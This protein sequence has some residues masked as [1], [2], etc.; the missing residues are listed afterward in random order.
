MK[1]HIYECHLIVHIEVTSLEEDRAQLHL[2][3]WQGLQK[4]RLKTRYCLFWYATYP[5][6]S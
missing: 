1:R 2:T 5:L 3:P 6:V 4:R